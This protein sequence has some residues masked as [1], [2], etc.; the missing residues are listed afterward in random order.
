MSPDSSKKSSRKKGLLLLLTGMLIGVVMVFGAKA[1]I[2]Y[3]STDKFCDQTCHVHPHANQTWIKSTHYTTKSGVTTHCIQ[4]HLPAEGLEFYTEKARLGFQDVYGKLFKDVAKID[5]LSK[6]SFDHAKTFTYDSAC[7]KCHSILFSSKLSKKGVDGHLHYQRASDKLRCISC[8]MS[9]G[10]WV[11]QK[12][13]ETAEGADALDVLDPAAFPLKPEG[14]K[15]YT[16]I[17]PG[18]DVKFEMVAIPGGEFTMG[19]P[20]GEPLRRPDEGPQHR[21]RLNQ[22]WMGKSEVRWKEWDVFYAQRGT[23]GKE[24]EDSS[25][26][27]DAAT[28]P[29]PPYGSPDQ[30]WGKGAQPAITI[31]HHSAEVYCEWLSSVT[32]KKYRLPT[33]AEWEYAC[34][35]GTT[36]PYFFPGDPSSFSTQSWWNRLVGAKMDPIGRFAEFQGDSDGRAHPPSAMKPNPWGLLNMLGNVAEFCLDFYDPQAYAQY[37]ADGAVENPRG[38]ESGNEHVIR[39]GS[40]RSDAADLRSAARDHTRTDAWLMT[41]PQSPKS[42]WW[43]SDCNHVGFRVVREFEPGKPEEEIK[44]AATAAAD[45]QKT[46]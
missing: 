46:K 32:G 30:G 38:P 3:T 15:N 11:N 36:T 12:A 14:F 8:H 6:R 9:V 2:D 26:T 29:T 18:S 23:P 31:T 5:W 22:I 24:K 19:S 20:A 44:K 21:V 33:E 4:C 1:G 34:R 16:E 28:G 17:L 25:Y 41:D 42:I 43:Y 7:V 27:A 13:A 45:A 40:Y 35:A 10:H 37:P 39:G